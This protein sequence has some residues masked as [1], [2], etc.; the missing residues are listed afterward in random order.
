[1]TLPTEPPDLPPLLVEDAVRAALKEDLGRAGDIT[2]MATIPQQTTARAVL[3][4]RKSGVL[5]GLPLATAT[6]GILDANIRFDAERK[7]GDRLAPGTI[8]ARIAGLARPILSGERVALNYLTHLSGIATATAALVDAVAGTK[9]RICD[10]RKTTPGLRA[11]EK[12]SVRAAAANH[13]FG[14]DD[15]ILIKDNHIAVA[16][17]IAAAIRR[18]RAVAGHLIE[19][20]VELDDLAQIEEALSAGPDVIMLDNMEPATMRRAVEMIAGRATVEASGNVTL[21]NVRNIAAT[22]VD[23]ISS[24]W[25][26]H[27][28]PALDPALDI[29]IG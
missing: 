25:I 26:T 19:V 12:Y 27:S 20:E 2:T 4:A 15:A 6:F 8:I 18:A 23:V 5:S 22:G 7:D 21:A 29:E 28:A 17:S 3:V 24:G 16:G 13:R 9:A 10:T 14:L 1:M 11:F